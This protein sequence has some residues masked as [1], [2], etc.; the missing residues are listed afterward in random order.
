NETD[1]WNQDDLALFETQANACIEVEEIVQE[2]P[3]WIW[4]AIYYLGLRQD[5]EEDN[6]VAPQEPRLEEQEDGIVYKD[7]EDNLNKNE[8]ESDGWYPFQKDE[9]R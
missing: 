2:R 5:D 9:V 7:D 4:N 6:D 1:I 3:D 8:S